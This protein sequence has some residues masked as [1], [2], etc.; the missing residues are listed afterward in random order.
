MQSVNQGKKVLHILNFRDIAIENL[1]F[2][3]GQCVTQ[4]LFKAKQRQGA[5]ARN[6]ALDFEFECLP[7][8]D[9]AGELEAA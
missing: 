4:Q 8:I 7:D 2:V 3:F 5:C 6:F 9:Q 1:L